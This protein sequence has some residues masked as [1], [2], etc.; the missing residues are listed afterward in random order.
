MSESVTLTI[1]KCI[2][3]V[4]RSIFE[5]KAVV[6]DARSAL[7]GGIQTGLVLWRTCVLPYLLYNS[8][9]WFQMK[10]GDSEMLSKLQRLFLNTLLAVKN[11]PAVMMM[12]DLGMVEIPLLILKEKLLLYHHISCLPES[13]ISRRILE[14]QESLNFPSLRQEIS[15]F[16]SKFEVCDVKNFSK[17]RWKVFV[18]HGILR[19]NREILLERMKNYKKVDETS[20]SLEEFG[21]KEY[22]KKLNLELGRIRFRVRAKM[23]TSC[24]THYPGEEENIKRMFQCVHPCGRIDSLQTWESC[25]FYSSLKESKNLEDDEELCQFYKSVIR[26]RMEEQ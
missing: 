21:I 26:K 14:V 24:S 12:W 3:L 11:C 4:K 18:H 15:S 13:A 5:I 6:E 1:K 16:L 2:G 17:E 20:M 7:V 8:S 10:K 25:P 23:M 9:T 22:F 19:L